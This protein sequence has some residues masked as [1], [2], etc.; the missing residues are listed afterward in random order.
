M[1][2]WD[3]QESHPFRTPMEKIN[4]NWKKSK[5]D[6][7]E[8]YS[9]SLKYIMTSRFDNNK[10]MYLTCTLDQLG[11]HQVCYDRTFDGYFQKN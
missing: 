9:L 1:S 11:K 2:L 3:Y 10:C 6:K 4:E 8:F 7:S 5:Y